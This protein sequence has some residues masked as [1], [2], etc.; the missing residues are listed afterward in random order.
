MAATDPS[1][2]VCMEAICSGDLGRGFLGLGRQRF[3]FLR[4]HREAAAGLAGTRRFD[5]GVERKEI[6]LPGDFRDQPDDVADLRSRARQL[7][8]AG[9]G[10]LCLLHGPFRDA[11][12][13]LNLLQD[14][15]DRAFELLG[16]G[17]D[18]IHAVGGFDRGGIRTRRG[19]LHRLGGVGQGIRRILQID[20][21]HATPPRDLVHRHLEGIREI[22]DLLLR[23]GRLSQFQRF[24]IGPEQLGL[25]QLLLQLVRGADDLA[26]LVLA[27]HAPQIEIE[28]V[29]RQRAHRIANVDQRTGDLPHQEECQRERGQRDDSRR[30]QASSK[31]AP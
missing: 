22:A 21:G 1:V 31:A 25:R 7:D 15:I 2:A 23:L 17:R 24:L 13:D 19:A 30:C 16:R 9:V 10:D 8:D 11:A 14:A 28:L 18:R 5:R 6:G 29:V 27:A 26:D 3:H 12:G 20:R 4:D